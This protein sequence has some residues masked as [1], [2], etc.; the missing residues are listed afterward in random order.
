[1]YKKY[2]T[3]I[4]IA[5]EA[6]RILFEAIIM[7]QREKFVTLAKKN[8]ILENIN[9]F[10]LKKLSLAISYEADT[11]I[12]VFNSRQKVLWLDDA[13]NDFRTICDPCETAQIYVCR[14]SHA[15]KQAKIDINTI[16]EHQLRSAVDAYIMRELNETPA[17]SNIKFERDKAW[18][19]MLDDHIPS[20]KSN[21]YGIVIVGEPHDKDEPD[22]LRHLLA[23]SGHDCRVHLLRDPSV[24]SAG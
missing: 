6:N 8:R 2:G 9:E 23:K 22:W 3:P 1:M 10:L 11:H 14:C 20:I 13:R 24:P 12:D 7:R 16:Q 17:G 15:V 18:K 4:F 5:V 19:D 21:E